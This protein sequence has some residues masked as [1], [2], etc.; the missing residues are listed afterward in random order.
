MFLF[1]KIHIFIIKRKKNI[2]REKCDSIECWTCEFKFITMIELLIIFS[3][4]VITNEYSL[5]MLKKIRQ[6]LVEVDVIKIHIGKKISWSRRDSN[7]RPL[8][9][10]HN[11]LPTELRDQLI[12]LIGE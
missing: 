10:Q 3:A 1:V 5:S 12:F 4:V 8:R 9:Y 6:K 2:E 11:A 7:P